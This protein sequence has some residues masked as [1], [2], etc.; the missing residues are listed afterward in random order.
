DALDKFPLRSTTTAGAGRERHIHDLGKHP[1]GVIAARVF[2]SGNLT[3]S[4][5][6]DTA[7]TFD[8]ERFD[9]NTIHSTSSNT[10]RLTV[11]TAGKYSIW[12]NVSWGINTT[13]FRQVWIRLNGSTAIGVVRKAQSESDAI[14]MQVSAPYDLAVDDYVELVVHQNSGGALNVEAASNHSPEFGMSRIGAAGT[15][16][17]G[18]PGTDHGSLTGLGDDDH[19]SYLLATGSRVGS[20]GGA[21]DFGSNGIKADLLV[22]STGAAGVTI[23]SALA[24]TEDLTLSKALLTHNGG[25]EDRL[26]TKRLTF[27]NAFAASALIINGAVSG[28]TVIVEDGNLQLGTSVDLDIQT[29]KIL[30]TNIQ[31]DEG[32]FGGTIGI[33]VRPTSSDASVSIRSIPSGT[34][35]TSFWEMYNSSTL[36]IGKRVQFGLT[37]TDF[38]ITTGDAGTSYPISFVKGVVTLFKM[39]TDDSFLLK[40]LMIGAAASPTAMLHLDQ[41]ST[42]GAK[43]ALF[44][45]QADV[46]EEF[47]KF[48]GTAAAGNVAQSIVD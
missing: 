17:G 37:A 21:Q 10:S 7:L 34:A 38:V 4:T 18:A 40:P 6:T 22:E 13:G 48:V 28:N 11:K 15:S 19:T 3:I 1:G 36:D 42:T 44:L 32:S 35:T 27:S 41:T 30:T 46:S 25:I 43:P 20:T 29:N 24:V 39:D 31:M 5:A 45:D 16:G 8:S 9:T 23:S 33:E 26:G 14:I 12:G 2:N 47:I